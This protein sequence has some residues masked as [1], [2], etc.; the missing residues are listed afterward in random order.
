MNKKSIDKIDEMATMNRINFFE[1]VLTGFDLIYAKAKEYCLKNK[2]WEMICDID[3]IDD[4]YYKWDELSGEEKG[5]WIDYYG[6]LA[7]KAWREFNYGKCKVENGYIAED[8][9]FYR[10]HPLDKNAMRI[11]KTGGIKKK[12]GI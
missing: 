11:F 6:K 5:P 9:I 3:N 8:G 2:G 1:S 4:Y 7:D 10:D 12:E